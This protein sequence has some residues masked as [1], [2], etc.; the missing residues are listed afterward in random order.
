MRLT[1]TILAIL[2]AGL[3][4]LFIGTGCQKSPA[5]PPP[6]ITLTATD[7]PT[8]SSPTR[9]PQTSDIRLT[10][11]STITL[12]EAFI[13]SVTNEGFIPYV[14]YMPH[15]S[16][17]CLFISDAAGKFIQTT[18]RETCDALAENIINPTQI[19]YFSNW[20]LKRC[21]DSDC[22]TREFVELGRYHFSADFSSLEDNSTN[23]KHQ[24]TFEESF[25]IL[26]AAD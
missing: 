7:L 1:H 6:T 24:F 14:F 13:V 4:S 19:S 18:P 2:L 25:T 12:D 15:P 5:P 22:L 21:A 3:L 17:N 20:D 11:P 10:Y 8:V 16:D 26:P 9:P 23:G